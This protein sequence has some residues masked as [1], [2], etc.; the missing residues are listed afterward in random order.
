MPWASGSQP[1]QKVLY[2]RST[3][4]GQGWGGGG[5]IG[6]KLGGGRGGAQPPLTDLAP[7]GRALR[8]KNRTQPL[9]PDQ[10]S[11]TKPY[12]V[13]PE[14]GVLRQLPGGKPRMNCSLNWRDWFC[15]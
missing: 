14:N 9:S 4:S 5:V 13:L 2:P 3:G 15:V 7:E 12:F 8:L 10:T 6:R 11:P 1:G